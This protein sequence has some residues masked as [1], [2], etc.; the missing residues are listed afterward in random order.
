MS[1]S[2]PI[3][4]YYNS[5]PTADEMAMR[6]EV[7]VVNERMPVQMALLRDWSEEVKVGKFRPRQKFLGYLLIKAA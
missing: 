6:G 7:Q 1:D 4:I 2:R 3:P 5:L